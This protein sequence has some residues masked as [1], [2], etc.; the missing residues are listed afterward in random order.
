M[1]LLVEGEV[2]EEAVAVC[3]IDRPIH[4]NLFCTKVQREG[5]TVSV[6]QK[7]FLSFSVF[8]MNE[9][10]WWSACVSFLSSAA[11]CLRVCKHMQTVMAMFVSQPVCMLPHQSLLVFQKN[12]IP[13]QRKSHWQVDGWNPSSHPLLLH[14]ADLSHLQYQ[15]LFCQNS[16]FNPASCLV[17]H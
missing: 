11:V 13:C 5:N 8:L 10:I 9:P 1:R 15:H 2:S 12:Q 3:L 6:I 14:V 4:H 7:P 17:L 16:I